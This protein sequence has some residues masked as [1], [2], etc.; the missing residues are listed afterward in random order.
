LNLSAQLLEIALRGDRIALTLETQRGVVNETFDIVVLALP[1]TCLR[2]IK[3]VE[4]LGLSS[5]KQAAIRELGYGNNAKLACGTIS[6][7]WRERDSGLPYPS[8]GSFYSDLPFQTIWETSR[9]RPGVRG[10]ISNFLAGNALPADQGEA[11]ENLKKGLSAISPRIGAALDGDAIA[12][13]F[14]EQ[15][16]LSFGSYACAKAG[17]YTTLLPAAKGAELGGRLHFAGEHTEPE[18]LGYM[19]GAILSGNRAAREIVAQMAGGG[20]SAKPQ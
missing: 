18:F 7:P 5:S 14:W 3:G 6:R 16:F 8:N 15:H 1:F 4:A 20:N 12:S 10:I 2:R 13:F 11:F 17:Q 19:N 9:M